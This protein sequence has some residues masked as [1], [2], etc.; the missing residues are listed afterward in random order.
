MAPTAIPTEAAACR[1]AKIGCPR[2]RSIRAPSAFIVTSTTPPTKP[3]A[4][5][6]P[7]TAAPLTASS[8]PQSAAP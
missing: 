4:I 5:R 2:M 3:E 1:R 8:R 7:A 6:K